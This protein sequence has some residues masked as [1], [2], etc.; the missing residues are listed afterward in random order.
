[1][2]RE[3]LQA[4]DLLLP[5]LYALSAVQADRVIGHITLK[6]QPILIPAA[7][8]GTAPRKLAGTGGRSLRELFVRSFAVDAAHRRQGHGRALQLAALELARCLGC[9]QLRSWSSLDKT[10][11]YALKLELGF[12]VHPAIQH[13]AEGLPV[14]GVYFVQ[15][16]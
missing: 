8:P 16:V 15:V 11:N 2:A 10:A 12:A 5:G 4:P 1:M 6:M 14:C 3:V 7:V 13:T 9:Y